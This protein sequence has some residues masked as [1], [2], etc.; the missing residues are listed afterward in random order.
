MCGLIVRVRVVPRRTVVGDIDRRFDNLSGSHHQSTKRKSSSEYKAE[1]II[2][3]FFLVTRVVSPSIYARKIEY[4]F[5]RHLSRQVCSSRAIASL[6]CAFKAIT[7]PVV[8]FQ[9]IAS[10]AYCFQANVSLSD[11][12][13]TL[14]TSAPPFYLTV[15]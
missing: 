8:S 14:E 5:G 3:V 7:S 1:V 10:P 6:V 15:V 11:E 12:G 4:S 9:T 2:R 13:L